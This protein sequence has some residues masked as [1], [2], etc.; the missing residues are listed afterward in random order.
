MSRQPEEVSIHYKTD[1]DNAYLLVCPREA[2]LAGVA[3]RFLTDVYCEQKKACGVCAACRKIQKG[4]HPD[5][6]RLSPEGSS[7]KVDDVRRVAPFIAEKAYEGGKKTVVIERAELM[8]A[9][10]QNCLLKPVEEPPEN[11]LFLLL[12]RSEN[13]VLPT[14]ASRCVKIKLKPLPIAQAA[15]RLM[16]MTGADEN[17]AVLFAS[18][19]EGYV[20]EALAIMRDEDF[21]KLRG[22]VLD[23]CL[24]LCAAKNMGV[25]RHADF[26]EEEKESFGRVLKIMLSFFN[27]LRWLKL[28]QSDS[29]IKNKDIMESCANYAFNFTRSALS[30]IIDLLCEVERRQRFALNYRLMVESMLFHILEVKQT[31]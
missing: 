6:L 11:T 21:L 14:V 18:L 9:E 30:N 7:I 10:A 19:G 28:T 15:A 24:K 26:L 17:E 4:V 8:T 25:S 23:M 27:D 2:E 12:A 16:E 3:L 13:T 31:W 22:R 29:G 1:A 5:I 20:N